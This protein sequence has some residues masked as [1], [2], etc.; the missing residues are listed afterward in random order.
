MLRPF[1]RRGSCKPQSSFGHGS[2]ELWGNMICTN[3]PEIE[4]PGKTPARGH[5]SSME[6]DGARKEL[7]D[8]NN[9][10]GGRLRSAI[11]LVVAV[12]GLG[13]S[14]HF[15]SRGYHL[16]SAVMFWASSFAIAAFVIFAAY[17]TRLRK[18]W[19]FPSAANCIA[20]LAVALGLSEI[21]IRVVGL[22]NE[23]QPTEAAYSFEQAEGNK[24][25]FRKWLNRFHAEWCAVDDVLLKP[26]PDG[27]LPFVL[28]PNR[29]VRF[30]DGS[31]TVNSLGFRD[32]EFTVEKHGAYRIVTIG[33]STTMGLTIGKDDLPWP[34]VLSHLIDSHLACGRDVEVINGGVAAYDLKH[35]IRRVRSKILP[36][37]PDMIISYHGYNGFRYLIDSL[38]PVR[39][40][41]VPV[42]DRE[43]PSYLLASADFAVR[44][45]LFRMHFAT[46]GR[47]A[48]PDVRVED[49]NRT[50]YAKLYQQ[51]MSIAQENHIALVL[52]S[53]NMA[54]N[55]ES[56]KE[57]ITFY[58]ELQPQIEQIILANSL[59]TRMLEALSKKSPFTYV[60]TGYQLDGA[61]RGNYTDLVHFTQKG[62]KRLATNIFEAIKPILTQ[63]SSMNCHSR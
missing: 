12:G 4:S 13:L 7:N 8:L 38:P 16:N 33:E 62:R 41:R 14:L 52:C 39:A 6:N 42:F 20:L 30:F 37:K 24:R 47:S 3:L 34:T 44:A 25:A 18:W 21:G 27:I 56:P 22:T 45:W 29:A 23:P 63:E 28:N 49:L 53:F 43:R 58:Q 10:L 32:R 9:Q 36:L 50:E 1:R 54:V 11:K 31:I 59:H 57:V 19:I 40:H 2:Q 46:Q 26:D 5:G 35:N 51:L 15:A 55:E 48:P 61:Y 60:D 17:G